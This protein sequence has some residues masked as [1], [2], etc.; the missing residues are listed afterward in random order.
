MKKMCFFI[1]PIK[2]GHEKRKKKE[3]QDQ[4]QPKI[5]TNKAKRRTREGEPKK[6]EEQFIYAKN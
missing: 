3:K 4:T 5:N 6:V 2:C 1:I